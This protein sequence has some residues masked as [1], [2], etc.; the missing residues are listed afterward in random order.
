MWK[1]LSSHRPMKKPKKVVITRLIPTELK[2]AMPRRN[3]L[4]I[5]VFMFPFTGQ[6][7][8]ADV[9][10]MVLTLIDAGSDT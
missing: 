1:T 10:V 9:K 7:L 5:P 2:I 6:K 8:P 4:P 3:F